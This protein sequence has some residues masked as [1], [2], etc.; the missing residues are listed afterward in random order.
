MNKTQH[1]REAR[2]DILIM[3]DLKARLRIRIFF[4]YCI[5]VSYIF[6]KVNKKTSIKILEN[7]KDNMQEGENRLWKGM[8][9]ATRHFA[10]FEI[11]LVVFMAQKSK[12]S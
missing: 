4:H 6:K 1:T 10:Q 12:N 9:S 11:I 2:V 8:E 7:K 5:I 3:V